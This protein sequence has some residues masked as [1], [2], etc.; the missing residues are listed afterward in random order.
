MSQ[1]GHKGAASH[2]LTMLGP[3]A[4]SRPIT[5]P[6]IDVVFPAIDAGVERVLPKPIETRELLPVIQELLAA[7]RSNQPAAHAPN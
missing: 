4:A 6:L 2:L 5:D 3:M 1:T 7:Q